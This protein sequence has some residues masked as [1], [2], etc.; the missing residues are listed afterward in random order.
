MREREDVYKII[1]FIVF[2]ILWKFSM[3]G[4]RKCEREAAERRGSAAEPWAFM[5]RIA[6][7]VYFG[8]KRGCLA[9]SPSCRG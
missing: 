7:I 4:S 6:P 2:R 9:W 3:N 8:A 5:Y 1:F